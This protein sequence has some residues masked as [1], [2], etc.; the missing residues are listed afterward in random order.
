MPLSVVNTFH[1]TNDKATRST[2]HL[3]GFALQS[4]VAWTNHGERQL[5]AA[6]DFDVLGFVH[7]HFRFIETNASI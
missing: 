4:N 7:E 3:S 1:A 6:L 2:E 5:T